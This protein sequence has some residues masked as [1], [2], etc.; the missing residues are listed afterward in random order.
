[1]AYTAGMRALPP[2]VLLSALGLAGCWHLEVGPASPRP[3]VM[4]TPDRVPAALVLA[5]AVSNDDVIP[6]T[7]SVNEVPVHGWRQTLETGFHN[8]YGTPGV[9]G[10]KLEILEAELTFSPA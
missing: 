8:A 6:A 7:G 5:A 9:L 1:M 3:N 10:R 4:L 2:R